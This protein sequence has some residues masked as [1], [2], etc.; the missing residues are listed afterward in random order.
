MS[1]LVYTLWEI[2]TRSLVDDVDNEHDALTLVWENIKHNGPAIAETLALDVED[3]T[4]EIH[5]IASGQEIAERAWRE[6][7]A[8]PEKSFGA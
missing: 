3:E 5:F 6:L 4:G 7:G 8:V 2:H 1:D